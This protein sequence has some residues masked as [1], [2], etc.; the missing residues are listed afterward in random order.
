MRRAKISEQAKEKAKAIM[1]EK[2][3]KTIAAEIEKQK[4]TKKT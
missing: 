2:D 4:K 1:K 3:F